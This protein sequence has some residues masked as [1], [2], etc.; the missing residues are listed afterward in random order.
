MLKP[1]PR[2]N[3][4]DEEQG[5]SD[6]T[7]RS[8]FE[9]EESDLLGY[10]FYLT[11]RRAVAEEIV[12]EVFLQLYRKWTEVRNP[13]AWLRRS[14]RNK[15]FNHVR[16]HQ[17]EVFRDVLGEDATLPA[18]R[19]QD[20]P[21]EL[22]ARLE[23]AAAL[24]AMLGELNTTDQELVKLKYFEGLK[25]R[26]ISQRTGLTVSN[27]GYRLHHILKELANKLRPLGID[28]AE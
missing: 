21:E 7:L 15:A 5:A 12:Q 16:D 23:T 24:R 25:Y 18:D 26:E 10:A 22:L 17:R 11:G 27:V 2:V 13:R 1:T 14:V 20:P 4:C 3:Q 19:T 8:L 28:E 6:L 9:S